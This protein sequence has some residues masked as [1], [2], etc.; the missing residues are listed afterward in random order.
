MESSAKQQNWSKH[1][2]IKLGFLKEKKIMEV[3]HD[4]DNK[5]KNHL[6]FKLDKMNGQQKSAKKLVLMQMFSRSGEIAFINWKIGKSQMIN[7]Q[8]MVSIPIFPNVAHE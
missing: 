4:D 5:P 2:W 1:E 6:L 7:S 8:S 3:W